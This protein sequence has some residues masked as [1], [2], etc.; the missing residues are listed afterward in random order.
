MKKSVFTVIV[1]M[2]IFLITLSSPLELFAQSTH[3]EIESQNIILKNGTKFISSLDIFASHSFNKKLSAF[4]WIT[5]S[6]NWSEA[7]F[8]VAYSPWSWLYFGAGFDLE[9]AIHPWRIGTI[10]LLSNKL[11]SALFIFEES[12]SGY[13]YRSI[14]NYKINK[15]IGA[16]LMSEKRLGTEIRMEANLNKTIQIW[17]AGLYN[18][19]LNGLICLKLRF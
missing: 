16:G 6:Q 15:K 9:T 8:G 1:V 11:G 2:V 3:F 17:V 19:S 18:T 14:L 13:W 12:G 10:V 5:T 7:Y 4:A